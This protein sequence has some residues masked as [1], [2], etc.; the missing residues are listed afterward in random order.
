M[1]PKPPAKVFPVKPSAF[2]AGFNSLEGLETFTFSRPQLVFVGRSNVGKSSLL[3]AILGRKKLAI[4]SKTPG[5]TRQVNVY[6]WD[7]KVDLI[8][9]PGYGYA[10]VSQTQ[11]K[12]WSPLM[13][14]FFAMEPPFRHVYLLVDGR[15]GFK[16]SDL[17]MAG[18]L[19]DLGVPYEVVF[20]K[21]D[22]VSQATLADYAK[23]L[24]IVATSSKTGAGLDAFREQLQEL[25]ASYASQR[26]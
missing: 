9:L 12:T 26:S 6:A 22:K 3:N 24:P 17:H 18:F 21:T 19:K 4:T 20:T 16:D 8:D 7:Q 2:I 10:A 14:A 1:R 13:E 25:A 11:Q 5:R 15:H 23:G